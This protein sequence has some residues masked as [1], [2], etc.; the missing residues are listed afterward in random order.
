[1]EA[2]A[3][4]RAKLRLEKAR[5]ALAV[6]AGAKSFHD[7]ESAWFDFLIGCGSAFNQLEQGAKGYGR[8]EAWYGRVKHLRKNDP[9][10]RYVHFARNSDEHGNKYVTARHPD[11]GLNLGFGERRE[12]TITAVDPAT[13]AR[14]K[15]PGLNSKAWMYGPHLKLVRAHS[16]LHGDYC[17]PPYAEVDPPGEPYAF[18]LVA[19]SKIDAILQEAANFIAGQAG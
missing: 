9:V 4:E 1:M 11:G 8:S 17:D 16:R 2:I 15:D 13:G 3:I 19:V 6:L 18:G 5:C 12:F 14:S 10:L 7:A